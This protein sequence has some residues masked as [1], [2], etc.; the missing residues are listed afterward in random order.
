M[1]ELYKIYGISDCPACLRACAFLMDGYPE[2]EYVFINCDFSPSFREGVKDK[3]QVKT[4]PII[5]KITTAGER[6]I[7]GWQELRSVT[8]EAPPLCDTP[9]IR[10]PT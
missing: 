8:I 7:G 9:P 2:K 10:E 5:I 4:F 1:K 6:L 3:Y